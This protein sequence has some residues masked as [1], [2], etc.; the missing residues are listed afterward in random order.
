VITRFTTGLYRVGAAALYVNRGLGTT[1]MPI[2]LSVPAEI[3]VLTL[4]RAPDP[5]RAVS[6]PP[7][8][9]IPDSFLRA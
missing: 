4:R 5:A 2:R 9:A 8:M 3:A 6:D 1:G 7:E